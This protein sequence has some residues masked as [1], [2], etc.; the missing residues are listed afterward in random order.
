[1]NPRNPPSSILSAATSYHAAGLCVIPIRPGT[2]KPSCHWKVYQRRRPDQATLRRWFAKGH[3]GLAL[4]MGAVSGCVVCRDFD[5]LEAH[6]LWAAAHPELSRSLPTVETPRGRH[7][8]LR[9]P[10]ELIP[11]PGAG[12]GG[13]V[14]LDDGE[15]RLAGCYCLAPPSKHRSGATYRWLIPMPATVAEV[16]LIDL[17][18]SGL[19]RSWAQARDGDGD[20]DATERTES[21][22]STERTESTEKTEDNRRRL[23]K[24]EEDGSNG[25]WVFGLP[26]DVKARIRAA[27]NVT[28]PQGPG[29]RNKAV[30]ELCRALQAI[31][32]LSAADPVELEPVV[33]TWHRQALPVISTKPFEE[34]LIDFLNGWPKVR[35][36]KGA[37]PILQALD[38]AKRDIPPEA[39][40]YEQPGL[41][42]LVSLCRQ[43]QLRAGPDKPFYLGCRTAGQLLDVHHSVAWRWLFLLS[44]HG[45]IVPGEIGSKQTGKATRWFYLGDTRRTST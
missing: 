28:L 45:V 30:F 8:Y 38:V 7:V 16:P 34:T 37:E 13:V 12:A 24:P 10:V 32:E 23:R 40:R 3:N 27:I 9:L 29:R 21:T 22:E 44:K 33:R 42:L 39:A 15:L 4:V 35:F 14:P 5:V 17:G 41:R 25:K 43:L 1:M 6:Q 31:P 26:E 20:R 18:S 19:S 2:K 36:P 11:E